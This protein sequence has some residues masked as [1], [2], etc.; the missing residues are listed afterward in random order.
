MEAVGGYFEL[1]LSKGEHYHKDALK[2]N[3]ARN[4]F[5]YILLARSYKKVYIPYY[6]CDVMLQPLNKHQVEYE[7][8]KIDRNL[9]PVLTFKLEDHEAF[10]Y[11]NYFGLKQEC[12]ERLASIYGSRL[13]VDNAQAFYAPP[14]DGIDTFY[15]PRKFFGVP[16]GGY[17]YTDAELDILLEQDVSVNRMQHLIKR[18]EFGAE[19]AYK[20]FHKAENELDNSPIKLMSKI[21][22][23]ILFNIDYSKVAT[24]RRLNYLY[25]DRALK[26]CNR[27]PI[28]LHTNDVPMVYPFIGISSNMLKSFLIENKVFVAT[29]WPNVIASCPKDSIEFHLA[30]NIVNISIDQRYSIDN[31]NIV[32]KKIKKYL[33]I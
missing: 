32:L 27:M 14:I 22:E 18:I 13:I 24:T 7:F 28:Y 29:Y 15:S 5:E 26:E 6:T 17:L 20:L 16:D 30:E 2:L 8:Y 21:T 33:N 19:A 9:E 23:S 10:L 12:V 31:L 1:E 11:T 25:V 3:T 4:C